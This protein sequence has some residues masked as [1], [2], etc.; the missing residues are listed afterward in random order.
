LRSERLGTALALLG[1]GAR[2]I[3]A[4]LGAVPLNAWLH[5]TSHWHLE[6][7]PRRTVL[8]GLELGAGVYLNALAPD[9][10]A[11]ALRRVSA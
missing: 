7:L 4:V 5:E 6:V 3:R 11:A 9:E 1:E 8:A 10:A 2:R